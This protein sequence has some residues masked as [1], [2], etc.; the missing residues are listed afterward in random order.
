[1]CIRD[2]LK[3]VLGYKKNIHIAS[4]STLNDYLVELKNKNLSDNATLRAFAQKLTEEIQKNYKLHATNYIAY[5]L[6]NN[7]EQF[8]DKYSAEAYSIFQERMSKSI[9]LND[10]LVVKNF[11]LM[12]ANPVVNK[13]KLMK[14]A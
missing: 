8:K 10:E 2:S 3:G 7:S 1:M 6:M 13:F 12:Y 4:G 11:L 14:Y 5:D 9:D